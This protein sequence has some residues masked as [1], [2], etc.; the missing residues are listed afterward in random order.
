MQL[1]C[2]VAAC[3]VG[4]ILLVAGAAFCDEKV[5]MSEWNQIVE[6]IGTKGNINWSEGYV[7]A[8]GIGAPPEQ[9]IGKP[10]ARPMA[11][12]AATVDAY[13]NLLEIV[14]GVR[15]DATTV[16]KDFV[17]QS[18]VIN[19]QVQGLVK[20]AKEMKKEYLSDGTVEVTLRMSL[21]GDFAKV[22]V[23]KILE[24]TQ[25]P[26][27]APETPRPAAPAGVVY[28][29]LVIDARGLQARPAMSPKIL[30]EDGKEIYGS[31]NVDREYAV[32]QGM[33]GYARDLTAAQSNSR[34][35]NN[36]VTVKGLKADG[37]GR[38]D[39][40]ISNADASAIRGAADNITFLKKCRV[41]VVL[42]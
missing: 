6:Q 23:P 28:T 15:I 24:K 36:P 13:R 26:P 20:G 17:T 35:T 38:S 39:I 27:P 21:S 42:D 16:V 22:I 33:S 41:M 31:M 4:V 30:D 32:Q 14:N 25:T 11:L 5:S 7:E 19:A 2:I 40:V 1:K 12:R 37:Q 29:G 9:Y 10:N 18:D 8:V 34:V 3:I